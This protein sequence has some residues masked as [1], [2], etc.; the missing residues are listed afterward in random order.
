[1]VEEG[2]HKELI[3]KGGQ[4]AAMWEIQEVWQEEEKELE[5]E[6]EEKEKK[7]HEIEKGL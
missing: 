5:K 4:Y 2:T 1:V 7:I 3:A 6:R